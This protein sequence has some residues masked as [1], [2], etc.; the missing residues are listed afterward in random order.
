MDQVYPHSLLLP[1][2]ELQLEQLSPQNQDFVMLAI[3]K[4]HKCK[5]LTSCVY[6]PTSPI[7]PLHPIIRE[8]KNRYQAILGMR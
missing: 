8:K 7:L 5:P 6:P 2:S 3:N 4:K 1:V